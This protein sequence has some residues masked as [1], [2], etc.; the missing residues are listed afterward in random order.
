MG[1]HR[2]IAS[3]R[4][5]KQGSYLGIRVEVCFHYD[6]G[7]RIGGRIVRDDAEEPGRAI[8]M[9]DDGRYVLTTECMWTPAKVDRFCGNCGDPQPGC[10]CA[11]VLDR[12]KLVLAKRLCADCGDARCGWEKQAE[13]ERAAKLVPELVAEIE[14][15]RQQIRQMRRQT[16]LF[17]EDG[18]RNRLTVALAVTDESAR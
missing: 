4:F 5:P 13:L 11:D 12:A 16:E 18:D 8:I 7:A 14:R 3:D 2:N 1:S 9:L 6:T 15:A 10:G 17:M